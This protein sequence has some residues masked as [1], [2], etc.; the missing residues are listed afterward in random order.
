MDPNGSFPRE[1]GSGRNEAYL[2]P[3][4]EALRGTTAIPR[5]DAHDSSTISPIITPAPQESTTTVLPSHNYASYYPNMAPRE[6]QVF[7]PRQRSFLTTPVG[8]YYNPSHQLQIM[9]TGAPPV[10]SLLRGDPFAVVHA[11]LS[12]TGALDSGPIFQSPAAAPEVNSMASGHPSEHQKPQHFVSSGAM[13]QQQRSLLGSSS[14]Y[15]EP[16]G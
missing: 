9:S 11:H 16:F 3:L 8:D 5:F 12:T 6:Q 14:R 15:A 2:S 4:H 7:L 10:T 1:A 13:S